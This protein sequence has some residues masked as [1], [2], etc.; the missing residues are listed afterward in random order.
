MLEGKEP[1]RSM[2]NHHFSMK[3]PLLVPS[4]HGTKFCSLSSLGPTSTMCPHTP[5]ALP[6]SLRISG[7]WVHPQCL[8]TSLSPLFP[9]KIQLKN[10]LLCD[11]LWLLRQSC[12]PLGPYTCTGGFVPIA[13]CLQELWIKSSWVR[14][15]CVCYVSLVPTKR[16]A[17][18]WHSKNWER[19]EKRG[20]EGRSSY[21]TLISRSHHWYTLKYSCLCWNLENFFNHTFVDISF[22][23][24]DLIEWKCSM[25]FVCFFSRLY[26]IS[27]STPLMKSSSGRWWVWCCCPLSTCP[28]QGWDFT[29]HN[30]LLL[31][32]LQRVLLLICFSCK[33]PRLAFKT[34]AKSKANNLQERQGWVTE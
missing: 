28:Q 16:L 21:G 25:G 5:G 31:L 22:S 11:L 15:A 14:S 2:T 7:L 26:C 4:P 9:S 29:A 23:K 19:V 10:Q 24:Q 32:R 6:F 27:E 13:H 20:R 17:Q 30:P 18:S 34:A 1:K 3:N 33:T 12:A 8:C